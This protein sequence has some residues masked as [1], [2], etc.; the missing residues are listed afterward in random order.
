MDEQWLLLTEYVTPIADI[1]ARLSEMGIPFIEASIR[2]PEALAGVAIPAAELNRVLDAFE[3]RSHFGQVRTNRSNLYLLVPAADRVRLD[4]GNMEQWSVMLP[5]FLEFSNRTEQKIYVQ[6]QHGQPHSAEFAADDGIVVVFWASAFETNHAEYPLVCRQQIPSGQRDGVKPTG[7][8]LPILSPEGDT[9][10]ELLE[11]VLYILFDLPHDGVNAGPIL[12]YILDKA[13]SLMGSDPVSVSEREAQR[14]LASRRNYLHLCS[15]QRQRALNDL[16]DSQQRAER[17][18]RIYR[19]DLI[20]SL[21]DEA[22]FRQQLAVIESRSEDVAQL[23]AEYEKLWQIKGVTDIQ[24]FDGSIIVTTEHLNTVPL[25]D[26]SIR[27][28]GVYKIVIRVESGRVTAHNE[29]R[30]VNEYSHPHQHS[31]GELCLGN[32][33]EGIIKLVAAYEFAAAISILIEFLQN[34]YEDD[35]YGRRIWEWPLAEDSTGII[36]PESTTDFDDEDTEDTEVPF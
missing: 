26:G 15:N 31:D 17:D 3:V 30:R 23:E 20:R 35:T 16:R 34:I 13:F 2:E 25:S 33:T 5:V 22:S 6:N 27:D 4:S 29:T 19:G 9:I 1:P 24:V 7:E 14:R 32:I 11:D 10:A 12:R 28:L 18:V 21:R 36:V 8:G